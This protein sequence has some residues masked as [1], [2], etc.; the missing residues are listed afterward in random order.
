MQ[1]CNLHNGGQAS[2]RLQVETVLRS[3]GDPHRSLRGFRR[4]IHRA[5]MDLGCGV[6]T[7]S[8][9]HRRCQK[10]LFVLSS[11]SR[12]RSGRSQALLRPRWEPDC[13]R[14]ALLPGCLLRPWEHSR[15]P[16]GLLKIFGFLET[17]SCHFCPRSAFGGHSHPCVRTLGGRSHLCVYISSRRCCSS[18]CSS[19][20]SSRS[21]GQ[22]QQLVNLLLDASSHAS[23]PSMLHLS[24]HQGRR[25]P[26]VRVEQL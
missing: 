1:G 5:L 15:A 2:V 8:H 17:C 4:A 14:V 11:G 25:V 20:N 24:A 22:Q 12:V 19:S 13:L 23:S 21:D 26:R 6:Y 3:K 9:L 7:P 18:S 16:G 10:G